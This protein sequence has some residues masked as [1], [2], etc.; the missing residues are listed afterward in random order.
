[1]ADILIIQKAIEEL[2]A[3]SFGVTGQFLDIHEVVYNNDVPR[4]ERVTEKEDGT[5]IVYFP[6]VDQKFYLAI[7]LETVPAVLVTWVDIQPYHSVYFRASS[8]S[9]S[10]Q[11]LADLTKLT[12]TR[13]IKKG[14]RK[15]PN[16]RADI[17]W[18][19]S[20]I[21]FELNPGPEEFADKL[22]K[23]LDFLEQDKEG[24]ESLV[25]KANGYIQIYSSFHNGNTLIGGHHINIDH[26]KRM[27]KLKLE[28]DFDI[29]A[30]GNFF[31]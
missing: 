4:V 17:V 13:G 2:A 5:A 7:Y 14:D 31:K 8:E 20:A 18:K 15:N 11:E 29:S 25:K 10:L 27:S 9:L 21:Y 16:S 24:V 30:D 26:I 1:M 28:I 6:V 12:F 22:T 23:L 3:K 19:W